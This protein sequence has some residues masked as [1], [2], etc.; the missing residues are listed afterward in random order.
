[1]ADEEGWVTLKGG[2]RREPHKHGGGKEGKGG[3]W[4]TISRARRIK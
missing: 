3:Q 4:R 1:V 2:R